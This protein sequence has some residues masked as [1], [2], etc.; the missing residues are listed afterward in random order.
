MLIERLVSQSGLKSTQILFLAD[1]A[2]KRYKVYKIPKRA[3]GYRTI[4]QPTRAIKAL[5]RWL[6]DFLTSKFPVHSCSTAY[7]VGASIR[8]NARRHARTCFTLRVDFREFFPSF[9]SKH[10]ERFLIEVGNGRYDIG[11][12]QD[13]IAFA[14]KIYC[15]NDHL[16]IGAPSSPSLTNVMMFEFDRN[17]DEWCNQ[18]EMIYTRYADDI[19]ISTNRPNRLSNGLRNIIGAA[20]R[21]SFAD[22]RVNEGKTAFLSKRYRRSITGLI[23][24]PQGEI[25]IGRQRKDMLKKEIYRYKR[26]TL[27]EESIS[28]LQGNLAFV[29]DVEPTFLSIAVR[30]YGAET[31]RSIMKASQ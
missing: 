25:S 6:T 8:E 4:E 23:I 29:N 26:G 18:E 21:Y 27:P 12:S 11:L 10:V 20:E 7:S 16:T 31:I 3:G 22:L 28:R 13:D 9:A 24:T 15:R 2:S 30:K 19:F 14:C 1:S 17:V 5:Q